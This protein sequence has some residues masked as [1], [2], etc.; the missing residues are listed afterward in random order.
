L[1]AFGL[2]AGLSSGF[3][4]SFCYLLQDG[5][6]S[7]ER[8]AEWTGLEVSSFPFYYYFLPFGK[9]WK[10]WVSEFLWGLYAQSDANPL[11]V[12]YITLC[13]LFVKYGTNAILSHRSMD[14]LTF[15]FFLFGKWWDTR[16]RAFMRIIIYSLWCPTIKWQWFS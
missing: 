5:R 12:V 2:S 3:Q 16:F 15:Y 10:P 14:I 6:A 11:T 7:Q 13:F 1:A 9:W 8:N 4:A